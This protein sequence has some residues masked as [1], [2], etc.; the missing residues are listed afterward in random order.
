[1]RIRKLLVTSLLAVAATGVTMATAHG[2]PVIAQDPIA[3]NGTNHGVSYS[4]SLSD[5]HKGV[6]THLSAGRFDLTPERDAV[7]VTAPD[8]TMI[9]RWPTTFEVAGYHVQLDP[10]LNEDGSTLT[11]RSSDPDT[12]VNDVGAFNQALVRDAWPQLQQQQPQAKDIGLLGLVFGGIAGAALGAVIFTMIGALFLVVG[13]IP[14][15][16]IGAVIGGVLGGVAGLF[17]L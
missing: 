12:V 6:T 9:E 3:I 1:M 7:T 16:L 13:A 11:L 14:G 17:L 10:E 15:F 5:D 2:E 4:T 8:G